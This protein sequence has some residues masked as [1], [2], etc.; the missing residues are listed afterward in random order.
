MYNLDLVCCSLSCPGVLL[1]SEASTLGYIVIPALCLAPFVVYC[2]R[3]L[4][5][6]LLERCVACAR[7]PD[8]VKIGVAGYFF[9]SLL[10]RY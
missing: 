4:L 9:S 7:N 2:L 1:D 5:R 10:L 6:S 3:R 8:G